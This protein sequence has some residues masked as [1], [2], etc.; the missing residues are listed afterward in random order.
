MHNV[1]F[2]AFPDGGEGG[3]G[4]ISRTNHLWRIDNHSEEM[5]RVISDQTFHKV[6]IQYM[7]VTLTSSY[8]P[9]V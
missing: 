1:L 3:G 7:H 5:K 2:S 9:K 4:V 8:I 6:C